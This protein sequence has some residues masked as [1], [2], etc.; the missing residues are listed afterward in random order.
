MMAWRGLL[1]LARH[2]GCD[3][4]WQIVP[5]AILNPDSPRLRAGT[6]A[7]DEA[8]KRQRGVRRVA[9]ALDDDTAYKV[10]TGARFTRPTSGASVFHRGRLCHRGQRIEMIVMS[11]SPR[12]GHR[13]LTVLVARI[14]L[15]SGLPVPF[16][17]SR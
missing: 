8:A 10:S 11:M 6:G 5:S 15:Q 14:Y 16:W 9:Q 13:S 17:L 4:G 3:V 7:G 12:S 1:S 2:T